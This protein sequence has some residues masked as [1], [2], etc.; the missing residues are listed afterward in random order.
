M[1]RF[2]KKKRAGARKG[3]MSAGKVVL[4]VLIGA[5]LAVP[6]VFVDTMI[7]YLPVV[8]Y[9][10]TLI[11]CRAY[12]AVLQRSLSFEQQGF[13]G[14]CT[15]GEKLAF[16]LN[17]KNESVLP[18]VAID[19]EFF[20][21]DLFGG[22]RECVRQRVSLPPHS[23][24]T[25]DF[26][27]QFDHIGNYKVGIRSV[28]VA[29]PFG[30]FKYV[31]QTGALQSVAVQP[32]VFE[33]P[34][35]EISA[36][37][38]QEAKR[39]VVTT[40][41]EGMDYATVR[42]YRWGD[43]IKSIHW[44]LSARLADGEYLTRLYETSCN[45]GIEVFLDLES[46]DYSAEELMDVYD[47]VVESGFSIEHWASR[48]GY[49][50]V[51][52]FADGQGQKRRYEGPLATQ[53]AAL[54]NVMPRIAPG[55]GALLID[56][57]Q[58][59]AGASWAQNNFIVCSSNITDGLVNALMSVRAQRRAPLLVAVV[60]HGLE[61]DGFDQVKQRLARLSAVNIPYALLSH[62]DELEGRG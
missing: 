62:A 27:V 18:A 47:A 31:K 19:A 2:G 11:I 51:L 21:S 5:L 6:A 28:H 15:R 42:E 34:G 33:I 23:D 59:E 48:R 46:A 50:S 14:E 30:I 16:K 53:R 26:A 44:K 38:T 35:I 37:S 20:I 45:P 9:V 49:E 54:V 22:E 24:K 61:G 55:S 39:P 17:I 25:F 8:A 41:D 40:I 12:L 60:P 56:L 1:A 10:F 29:D 13:G 36:E 43:P 52:L 4:L 32:R 3:N 58:S 57:L 7:G